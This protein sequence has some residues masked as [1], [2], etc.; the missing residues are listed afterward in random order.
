MT[1]IKQVKRMALKQYLTMG[2]NQYRIIKTQNKQGK[3]GR[4]DSC[5]RPNNL[6]EIGFVNCSA[7]GTL[8]FNGWPRKMIGHLFKTT[9][10]FVHH[11]K[12]I[13]EFKL[14]LHSG[15]TQFR[16][17]LAIFLSC[18][19][20]KFDGWT[21][22]RI[23]NILNATLSFLHH[24]KS[25]GKFNLKLQSGNAQFGSKSAIFLSGL[26]VDLEKQ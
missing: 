20:L 4:F 9:S 7:C 23:D 1:T 5:D 24:F 13:S 18:L 22:K 19:T 8:K 3:S 2:W 21:W 15:N 12:S 11:S 10:S 14:G 26:T 17:K 6:N 25:I 16:S